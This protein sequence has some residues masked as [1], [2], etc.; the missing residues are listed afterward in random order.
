MELRTR[1]Y[2]EM[3]ERF[4]R[5]CPTFAQEAVEYRPKHTNAIRVTLRNGTQIDFNGQSGYYR[6]V[7]KVDGYSPDDITDDDCRKAFAINLAE[8]MHMRGI[9]QAVLS[10]RTGLS[11]AMISKYL[12]QKATPTITNLRKIAHA[13]DCHIDELIE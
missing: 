8:Y 7:S 4:V 2:E 13:L 6:F 10:E 12:N 3:Y 5:Q 9:G 1:H 11:S